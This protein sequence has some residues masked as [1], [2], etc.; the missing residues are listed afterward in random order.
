M[1]IS[2][3]PGDHDGP[4]PN[5]RQPMILGHFSLNGDREFI[6]DMSG[7]QYLYARGDA[8][9]KLDLDHNLN[10]ARKSIPEKEGEKINNLLRGVLSYKKKFTVGERLD[11]LNTDVVCFRGLLTTI[12]CTPYEKR[13]DW[14]MEVVRWR[15][16][17]YLVQ[18]D[19]EKRRREKLQETPRQRQMSSW[20]YKFEQLMTSPAPGL[21]PDA[22]APVDENEEFCCLFRTRI[23]GTS[24]VYGAEM[25]A[26]K[27]DKR[28]Q[29]GDALHT[30]NFV[31]MKTS[32]II[33]HE[34][35]DRNFRRFKLLKWW[36]QSFLV[37]TR[38]LLCG[39][40]DDDGVVSSLETFIIKDIPKKASDWKPNVCVN[41]LSSLLS[42]LK[43]TITEESFVHTV[44]W[45][46]RA[47]QIQISKSSSMPEDNLPLW[48]LNSIFDP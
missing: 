15:G 10:L 2:V 42:K 28:L 27:A 37:G 20:G 16:T 46:S 36:S 1:D 13:D 45:N 38:E 26:Y 3:H 6:K 48:Y 25:D 18:V 41:F 21:S 23:N 12:M 43:S 33:E 29:A 30:D 34:R 44:T 47:K 8:R 11:N 19:T 17:L 5:F 7:L 9:V 22:E 40:R 4:F 35:Q 31:E 14:I 32:R 24:I 39:W